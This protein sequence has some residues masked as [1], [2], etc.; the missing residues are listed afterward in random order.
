MRVSEK[1]RT[2]DGVS[3]GAILAR[4]G[5]AGQRPVLWRD[6]R[7]SPA[8]TAEA[9]TEEPV[10]FNSTI[11]GEMPDGTAVRIYTLANRQGMVAKVTEYGAILTELWVPDR[12]GKA[13]DVVLGGRWIGH[14]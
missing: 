1:D 14:S 10:G 13:G 4:R 5:P 8:W 6:D 3:T 12:Q 2:Q 7:A 11:T 9:T